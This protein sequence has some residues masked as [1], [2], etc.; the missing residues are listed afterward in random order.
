MVVEYEA[1][2]AN[3]LF[4]EDIVK[5][6]LP[7]AGEVTT[8]RPCLCPWSSTSISL[9]NIDLQRFSPK[10]ISAYLWFLPASCLLLFL[11]ISSNQ[12]LFYISTGWVSV[13]Q[14][15][16]WPENILASFDSR[17]SKHGYNTNWCILVQDFDNFNSILLIEDN[18]NTALANKSCPNTE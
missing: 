8:F 5:A 12:Q 11:F 18:I 15:F 2:K 6:V 10:M 1:K 7:F 3:T 4:E 14:S 16:F 17:S 13:V 9:C